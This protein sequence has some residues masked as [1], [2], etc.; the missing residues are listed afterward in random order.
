MAEVTFFSLGPPI[1][2]CLL[3]L[4]LYHTLPQTFFFFTLDSFLLSAPITDPWRDSRWVAN[5]WAGTEPNLAC[6]G[7]PA[8]LSGLLGVG[9]NGGRPEYGH[10]FK[11][12]ARWGRK[13]FA[14]RVK[15][16]NH[17][18]QSMNAHR[19]HQHSKGVGLP[20][21]STY[22]VWQSYFHYF[23]MFESHLFSFPIIF[24]E[25]VL[26]TL[27]CSRCLKK[28]LIRDNSRVRLPESVH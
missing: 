17:S 21:Q 1:L 26:C 11:D 12:P 28:C 22:S 13:L 27:H 9:R 5:S 16:A 14:Q 2:A 15:I 10:D 19:K 8:L 24:I 7:V 18:Q 23:S 3:P 20:A 4:I 6:R 25:G